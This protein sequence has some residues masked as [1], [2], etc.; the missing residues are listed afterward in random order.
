MYSRKLAVAAIS[1][2]VLTI[3]A[4]SGFAQT[5]KGILAGTA[6]DQTGAVVAN[7]TVTATN[8]DNGE[9][10]TVTTKADGAYRVESITPGKYTVVVTQPG[11]E[12]AVVKDVLVNASTTTSYDVAL[13][14]G[15]ANTEVSVEANQ[16]TINTENGTLT[17]VVG[18]LEIDK[19]PIFSLNP[20]ELATTLPGVQ[21]V[22]N[23]G[24]SNGFAIQVNGARPRANN[25]LLDGQEI[26]DVGIGGQ[27]FQPIIPDIFDSLNVI[28]NS[29]SAEFGR[30]GGG[31]VNL[32]TK[33]GTNTYHG[34]VFERYQDDGL[35]ARAGFQRVAGLPITP[36]HQNNYGFTAGGPIIKNKL[37]AFGAYERVGFS[38]TVTPPTL[39]LP[40]AAG[41]ATLQQ[42]GGANVTLLDKYLSNGSYL[43]Q[44]KLLS[45]AVNPA[46]AQAAIP[47]GK[48][49]NCQA[50]CLIT[51]GLFQRPDLAQT[52]PDTQYMVRGD[53]RLNDFNQFEF[54]YLHNRSAFSPDFGN[55]L[56][57]LVGFDTEQGGPVELAQTGWN[58]EFTPSLL[59]EARVSVTRL[60]FLFSPTAESSANPLYALGTIGGIGITG[61]GPN[62]NI[63]QGRSESL[64]QFQDTVGLVKGRQAFRVGADIGRSIEIDIVSLNAK[65]SLGFAPTLAGV[66]ANNNPTPALPSG[67]GSFLV[68]QLG[69]GGTAT[70][71]FGKT[72][73]DSHGYRSG[74]FAQDDIKLSADLTVNLGV[75]YDYLSNPENSLNY[76]GIDINNPF[77]VL[78][79][80]ANPIPGGPTVQGNTFRIKED[81]KNVSPRF[82]FAYSPHTGGMIGDGK[83]VV[84]GGF[85]IFY[86]STFSN[87]LTNSA[88]AAPN[89]V[90]GLLT[91]QANGGLTN[92]TGQIA[93]I[94]PQLALTST[95]TSEDKNLVNPITYQYNLGVERE[96]PGQVVLAIRYVGNVSK[97]Q[98][99]TTDLNYRN[100]VTGLRL[101]PT[102]GAI[103]VRGNF[104][105]SNY[106]SIEVDATHNFSHGFLVRGTYIFSKD[107]DN[108]SEVFALGSGTSRPANLSPGGR[109]QDYG[110]SAYDHRHYATFT[111][112]W[113]PKGLHSDN[114]VANALLGV[115]TRHFTL[116]GIEQLQSGAYTSN[117]INGIDTNGDGN[118]FND[119]PIVSNA[120]APLT[121]GGLDGR[122]VGGTPDTYYDIANALNT[123]GNLVQVNPAAVHFLVPYDKR[124]NFG[125]FQA[126]EIG[127]NAFQNPGLQIHNIAIEKGIGLS[128][129]HFERGSLIFRAEVQDFINHNNAGILNTDVLSQGAPSYLDK[130]SSFG[131]DGRAIVL[132]GKLQF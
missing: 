109:S 60:S 51:R 98:F 124:G 71:T 62:Q 30:A 63:P 20:I 48:Q 11:F 69:Q 103:A 10:R 114:S 120:S 83:T 125:K 29:A 81:L 111:Y 96:I 74:F 54:R 121:T 55:S 127:R 35:D 119:R 27:A 57:A 5:S 4:G 75:R 89:A 112:V 6:R 38:G 101:D 7:A 47:V 86:D 49:N 56:A 15:Q 117:Q 14:V 115:F 91:S 32:V 76:P 22:A 126:K 122:Y 95:V 129:L 88:S 33:Q 37:F 44:Y 116:S 78:T 77:G 1:A 113:S 31:I 50:P 131:G 118:A 106:N 45:A 23:G 105:S 66:D 28:T 80:I 107:L 72:R 130:A 128:Y 92:A 110:N 36:F 53:Y 79:L 64:Y 108:G 99:G 90:A 9:S 39:V 26:N 25:F 8:Q 59:N 21:I 42:I 17:G 93:N 104:S 40:D 100:G 12:K 46:N 70:K 13:Q 18:A 16:A 73:V 2:V 24:F 3:G 97:K 34:T 82:G 67:L 58:H 43:T 123:T 68:N 52:A 61:I 87:I 94:A 84:R 41:Y 85:G 102:R 65:G 19:L 132:W